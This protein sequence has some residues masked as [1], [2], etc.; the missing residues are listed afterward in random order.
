MRSPHCE[1]VGL[2][3][4]EVMSWE[5]KQC[6]NTL[7]SDPCKEHRAMTHD[8]LWP[9]G[10]WV[11]EWRMT[12]WGNEVLGQ[13][14]C[15]LQRRVNKESMCEWRGG[16]LSYHMDLQR[17]NAPSHGTRLWSDTNDLIFKQTACDIIQHACQ[18]MAWGVIT[19][20]NL[21]PWLPCYDLWTFVARNP[22]P[23]AHFRQPLS[24]RKSFSEKAK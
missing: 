2:I 3:D 20:T 12:W 9:G 17:Q 14:F 8:D 19:H 4:H 23:Q 21:L 11:G 22:S 5:R 18:P 7:I 16:L 24:K 10:L 6:A 15:C 1:T 13:F